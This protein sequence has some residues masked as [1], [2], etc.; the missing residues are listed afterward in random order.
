M[1]EVDRRR[2]LRVGLFTAGLLIVLG[3]IIVMLGKKQ[4]LFQRH[5]TYEARF[6]H[7]G[8]LIPG[9]TVW[10]NGVVVG[11]VDDVQLPSDPNQPEITVVLRVNARIAERIR[12]DS[13]V[14]IRTLGLLGDRYLE[15]S[16][17]SVTQPVLPPGSVIPST[18]PTD[19]SAVLSRGGD[20]MTNILA[21]STSLRKILE[22]VERGEGVLGELTVNPESGRQVVSRLSSVL[23]TTDG[24]L[25]DVR[26]GK[27]T[28]GR[29][30]TD[31]TLAHQLLDDL[32]GMAHAGRQVGEALARDLARDDS[33]AAG[34]LKDP[35][36]RQR[37]QRALDS[38]A[39]AGTAAAAAGKDLT[40]GKGVLPRLLND[41]EYARSFLADL[42][43]LTYSLR[44]VADKLDHGQGS[45]ARLINDP[46][47]MKDLEDVV[48]GVQESKLATWFIRNR[49]A[50]GERAAA[51][52]KGG[53]GPEGVP[54]PKPEE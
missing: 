51:R 25:K 34:L 9:A 53:L 49:R 54:T 8:G 31:P 18:E 22:R 10:L 28:L 40:E 14:R 20:A 27:G 47:L 17:G 12:A 45:A 30:I 33:V 13:R 21:I 7:V 52:P 1:L 46:T 23:E 42:A 29:L 50:A 4:G 15:I 24:I 11:S 32:E 19:V 3:L 2:K 5:V 44:Q 26:Q 43:E 48:R 6:E 16:S 39:E 35:Q 37:L 36:G 38:I 41:G